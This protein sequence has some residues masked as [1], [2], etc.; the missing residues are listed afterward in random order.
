MVINILMRF[1]EIITEG[2]DAPLFHFTSVNLLIRNILPEDALKQ[3]KRG[4]VSLTRNL[5]TPFYSNRWDRDALLILNQTALSQR[6]KIVPMFG[7]S[8]IEVPALNQARADDPD[9]E[10]ASPENEQEERVMADIA[11][12]HKY[13]YAIAVDSGYE[14]IDLTYLR[15]VTDDSSVMWTM[16][17]G[18]YAKK[19][20]VK[21]VDRA[22]VRRN[23]TWG[24]DM[25]KAIIKNAAKIRRRYDK[26]QAA[27]V[28]HEPPFGVLP[29]DFGG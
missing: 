6:F 27:P 18:E 8:P 15:K 13:L 5:A 9:H 25:T 28:D 20:G 26:E 2:R 10:W 3:G 12:L 24:K 11:P 29:P 1:H 22:S 19:T 14:E 7:D 21:L 16:Y 23:G 4:G 17:L